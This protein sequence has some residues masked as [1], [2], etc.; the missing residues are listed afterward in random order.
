MPNQIDPMLVS[1]VEPDF[2]AIDAAWNSRA[3]ILRVGPVG[4]REGPRK[5][6]VGAQLPPARA[7]RIVTSSPSIA[8]SESLPV[9]LRSCAGGCTVT[10]IGAAAYTHKDRARHC[11]A[12]ASPERNGAASPAPIQS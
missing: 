10:A 1:A 9:T 5:L 3:A 4:A 8:V 11:R 2:V 7:G 6:D 12:E